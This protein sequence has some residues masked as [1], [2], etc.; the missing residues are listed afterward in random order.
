MKNELTDYELCYNGQH[1]SYLTNQEATI[2]KKMINYSIKLPKLKQEDKTPHV[3]DVI[4][5]LGLGNYYHL[6]FA[7][8]GFCVRYKYL[9][10]ILYLGT[11]V[12]YPSYTNNMYLRSKN[13]ILMTKKE[14]R[15]VVF[16]ELEERERQRTIKYMFD[17]EIIFEDERGML[18]INDKFIIK[19]KVKQIYDENSIR[20]D[21]MVRVFNDTIEKLYKETSPKTHKNVDVLIK[22]LPY[23]NVNLSCVCKLEDV[24]KTEDVKCLT[25]S[26]LSETIGMGYNNSTK[27]KKMLMSIKIDGKCIVG[28]FTTLDAEII[29]I[30]PIL[31]YKGSNG[32]EL[33]TL[34]NDFN[35]SN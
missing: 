29:K 31:F 21:I 23:I 30:N 26:Q 16:K 7:Y 22:I 20:S 3:K 10:R 9:L 24:N 4:N 33:Y 17:N 1:I 11:F 14:L 6:F 27:L 19:G 25:F 5:S 12:S 34:Y 28:T 18:Y 2:T 32:D 8:D 35:K 13:N 15:T